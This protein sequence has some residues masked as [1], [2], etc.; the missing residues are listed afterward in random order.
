MDR[1]L[2]KEPR[3]ITLTSD[4]LQNYFR[5]FCSCITPNPRFVRLRTVG[6]TFAGFGASG[7]ITLVSSDF[8]SLLGFTASQVSLFFTILFSVVLGVGIICAIVSQC[9]L[10]KENAGKTESQLVKSFV[11]DILNE[12]RRTIKMGAFMENRVA[13]ITIEGGNMQIHGSIDESSGLYQKDPT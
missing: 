8:K 10:W 4:E 1:S 5:D 7:L 13:P 3:N 9:F 6:C 2:Y 11:S 12:D